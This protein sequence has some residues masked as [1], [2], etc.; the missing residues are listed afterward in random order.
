MQRLF[1]VL[2]KHRRSKNKMVNAGRQVKAVG[3]ISTSARNEE[4]G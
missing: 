1:Y 2:H 3:R 4:R